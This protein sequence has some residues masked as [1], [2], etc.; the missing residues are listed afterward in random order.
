VFPLRP[1]QN[2]ALGALISDNAKEDSV[3]ARA[4]ASTVR[5][6]PAAAPQAAL[7]Q[8]TDRSARQPDG[9]QGR[10]R[11]TEGR[12]AIAGPRHPG[13]DEDEQAAAGQHAPEDLLAEWAAPGRWAHPEGHR[14]SPIERRTSGGATSH[15]VARDRNDIFGPGLAT[16]V[17]E[18]IATVM[19][20]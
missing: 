5:A 18:V 19:A 10:Q 20:P 4:P 14:G 13:A 15:F 11:G 1:I 9:A 12:D 8:Q 16:V 7:D 17:V 6:V 3:R 2:A